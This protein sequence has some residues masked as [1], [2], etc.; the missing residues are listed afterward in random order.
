[1]VE[2]SDSKNGIPILPSFERMG[3]HSNLRLSKEVVKSHFS[4]LS[5]T[6]S[7]RVIKTI[8]TYFETLMPIIHIIKSFYIN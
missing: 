4:V 5:D 7:D 3:F 6:F 2:Q 8:F 1:M